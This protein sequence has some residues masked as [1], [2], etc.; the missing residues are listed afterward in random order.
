MLLAGDCLDWTNISLV[1]RY[2]YYLAC[3]NYYEV[4]T[5]KMKQ[6]SPPNKLMIVEEILSKK[7][8]LKLM[9]G[10]DDYK[11]TKSEIIEKND[12]TI[13]FMVDW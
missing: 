5:F 13:M 6:S 7:Y 10:V 4:C 12:D 2:K 1:E 11:N 8:S 9:D 3:L